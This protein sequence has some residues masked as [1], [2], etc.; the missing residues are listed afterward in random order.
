MLFNLFILIIVQPFEEYSDREN[1]IDIFE[2]DLETIKNIWKKYS[3]DVKMS[4]IKKFSLITFL[5][6]TPIYFGLFIF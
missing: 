1:P 2:E 5:E 4:K 3:Y 6:D